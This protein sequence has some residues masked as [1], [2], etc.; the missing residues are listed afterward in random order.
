MFGI[1]ERCKVWAFIRL[2]LADLVEGKVEEGQSDG[3]GSN[4]A[5]F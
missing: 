3:Y 5:D 4:F 1:D 2:G